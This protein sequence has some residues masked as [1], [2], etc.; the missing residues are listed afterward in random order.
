MAQPA[1]ISLSG[2]VSAAPAVS[3]SSK[4]QEILD[5]SMKQSY[6]GTK[7]VRLSINALNLG[8]A[9]VIPFEGI[10]VVRFLTIIVWS[11]P[12]DVYLTSSKGTDQV[13]PCSDRLILSAPSNAGFTAI[14]LVGVGD[15]TYLLAGDAN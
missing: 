5:V 4:L 2:V 6:Q 11:A 15:V 1:I 7:S 9:Y 13:I 14:K 8:A 3:P 12:I 10:G